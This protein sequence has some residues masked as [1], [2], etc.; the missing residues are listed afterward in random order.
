MGMW[1]IADDGVPVRLLLSVGRA[2][3]GGGEF[4]VVGLATLSDVNKNQNNKD[5]FS[6]T[7]RIRKRTVKSGALY[8]FQ[9][10]LSGA[11][12]RNLMRG[13]ALN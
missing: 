12:Q 4:G 5:P 3:A 2:D 9:S 13:F 6:F 1:R 7:V 11:R 10:E 8:A